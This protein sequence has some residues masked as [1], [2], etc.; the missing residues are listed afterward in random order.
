[1][2]SDQ[3]L[4]RSALENL[5]VTA[6]NF[7]GEDGI[8]LGADLITWAGFFPYE[9]L[10]LA[11]IH[12][13]NRFELYLLPGAI[14]NGA[15]LISGSACR[16]ASKGDLVSLMAFAH[17]SADLECRGAVIVPL[18]QQASGQDNQEWI[19]IKMK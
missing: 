10:L 15:C 8:Y 18:Q 19:N 3:Q 13:G 6:T 9:R 4:L 1:M 2:F 11:N 12:N 7:P 14:Q 16:L 17:S 5:M